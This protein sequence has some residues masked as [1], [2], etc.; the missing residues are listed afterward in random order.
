MLAASSF[1]VATLDCRWISHA[2]YDAD[3]DYRRNM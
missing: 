3:G 1:G 2:L